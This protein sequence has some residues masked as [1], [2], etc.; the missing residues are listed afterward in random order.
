MIT[1]VAARSREGAIGKANTIPWHAP[2]DLS[3]FRR[4]TIGAAVIMGRRTWE[5]LP[6]KPLRNRDNLVVSRSM[7]QAELVFPSFEAAVAKA[8]AI[9]HRRIYVIGGASIYQAALPIADRL[10]LTEVAVSVS[11]ADT[12][13]PAFDPDDWVCIGSTILRTAEPGCVLKEFMRKRN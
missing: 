10:L 13:F 6:V 3:F 2:E 9:G 5:S 11:D 7:E 12:F 8:E 4:E 1:I